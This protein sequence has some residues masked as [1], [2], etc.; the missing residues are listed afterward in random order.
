MWDLILAL[1]IFLVIVSASIAGF[2]CIIFPVILELK[3]YARTLLAKEIT[4][5]IKDM[6]EK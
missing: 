5:A 1:T 4:A 6:E 3:K 2:L